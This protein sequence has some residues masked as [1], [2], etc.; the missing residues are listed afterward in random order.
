MAPVRVMI[1]DDNADLRFLLGVALERTG[2]FEVVAEAADGQEGVV[3]AR[4]YRPELVILD[5]AMPIMDGV[6]ALP[7]LRA[8]VPGVT[9]VVL[10]G[11]DA[12]YLAPVLL[13]AGAAAYLEKGLSVEVLVEQVL[14]VVVPLAIPGRA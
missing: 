5:V 1:I 9:V 12:R 10:S 14:S 8:A 3:R 6:Q 13:G 4:T 2:R 7:E 11:F